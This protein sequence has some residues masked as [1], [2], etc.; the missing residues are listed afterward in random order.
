MN[1]K[2]ITNGNL[3]TLLMHDAAAGGTG[4]LCLGPVCPASVCVCV[5][6]SEMHTTQSQYVCL[7]VGVMYANVCF[8]VMRM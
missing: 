6:H 7:E 2:W 3:M 5:S 8:I 4:C 1:L